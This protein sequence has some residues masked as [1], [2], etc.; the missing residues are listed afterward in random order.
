MEVEAPD[1]ASAHP[2]T[3]KEPKRIRI[4]DPPKLR[5]FEV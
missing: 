5:S 3:M 4:A 2:A 1:S